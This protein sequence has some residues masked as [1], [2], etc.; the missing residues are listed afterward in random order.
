[1]KTLF[2]AIIAVSLISGPVAPAFAFQTEVSDDVFKRLEAG[3]LRPEKDPASLLLL[4]KADNAGALAA[5][6]PELESH[7][8]WLRPYFSGA[9]E[10]AGGLVPQESEH[11]TLW[12][13]PDQAFLG[14][15]ALPALEKAW[16]YFD[17]A[18]GHHPSGKVRVEIYPT[19]EAFSAASTLSD[20]T[21]ERSGAIGICKFHRLMI[22]TPKALPTGYRWMDALT[23]EYVHLMVNEITLSNAELWLHEGTARYFETAPRI[24]PPRFLT[25]HQKTALMEARE[26]GELVPF[27]KMSPS[28]VYLKD[29]DQVGLAFAQVSHAVDLMVKEKGLKTYRT[30]LS[31]LSRAPFPEAFAKNFGMKPDEFEAHWKEALATETWQKS[32]GTLDDDVRF[33]AQSEKESIGAGVQGR[34]RLGDKMR[35]RGLMDAALIEF[36]KALVEEPDNAVILLK[37]ARVLIAL[38]RPDDAR[39]NLR[40]AVDKNANYGTPWLELAA[41]VEPAEAEACLLEANAINPFDPRIHAGLRNTYAKRGDAVKAGKE[42][43]I[44]KVLGG[45]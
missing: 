36:E 17:G 40:R 33:V 7:A 9:L 4:A 12:T 14:D 21:L 15:Y 34:V 20:E 19:K 5:L 30:F 41:L 25:E 42:G 13:T 24:S 32:R 23:H 37:A 39:L 38:H 35:V 6:T 2:T 44:V 1:M 27:A 3:A 31:D 28:M 45:N 43:E 22:L 18:L 26:K 16:A 10:A 29:Q 8:P 11:F